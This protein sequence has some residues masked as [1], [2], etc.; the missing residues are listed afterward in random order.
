MTPRGRRHLRVS[1]V[2]GTVVAGAVVAG[3]L[4]MH[5]LAAA[6]HLP[7]PTAHQAPSMQAGMPA[8]TS[9]AM[10][11]PLAAHRTAHGPEAPAH[12]PAVVTHGTCVATPAHDEALVAA[13][14]LLGRAAG[15]APAGSVPVGQVLPR[16]SG[17]APPDL[18]ELCI[19]RT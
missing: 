16:S 1:G 6:G 12:A 4:S 2:A 13:P 17:R 15:R 7:G 11:A 9:A 3:I 8:D 18:E 5:G 10:P 14:A 19:S